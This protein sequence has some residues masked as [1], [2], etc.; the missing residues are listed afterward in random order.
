MIAINCVCLNREVDWRCF[1]GASRCL[2]PLAA[3]SVFDT[4][5]ESLMLI[6][7]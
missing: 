2:R 1:C 3:V 6:G 4:D 5:H 7:G